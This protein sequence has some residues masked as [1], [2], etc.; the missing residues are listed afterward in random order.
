MIISKKNTARTTEETVHKI[1]RISTG[2][3]HDS[4]VI[5]IEVFANVITVVRDVKEK[6]N[7]GF[8]LM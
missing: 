6:L 1:M 4:V 7:V 3:N 5:T 8:F 2:I